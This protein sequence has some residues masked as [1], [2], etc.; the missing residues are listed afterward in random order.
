MKRPCGAPSLSALCVIDKGAS[1]DDAYTAMR[2]IMET[3]NVLAR[4]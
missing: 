1:R 2:L 3:V 4:N